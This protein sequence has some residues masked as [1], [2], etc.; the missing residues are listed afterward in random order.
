M[1]DWLWWRRAR[2]ALLVLA[3]VSCGAVRTHRAGGDFFPLAPRST[4]EYVISSRGGRESF[5]FVATVRQGEFLAEDGSACSIVDERYAD[6]SAGQPFPVIYCASGGFLHRVMSLEYQGEAL[7]DN[8][9]RSGETK[10][11]PTDLVHARAWEGRTNAYRLPDGSGFDVEQYHQ[12]AAAPE[13]V[14]VPAGEFSRCVRVET[15][16]VHSAIGAGG[17]PTGPRFVYYYSDW[18]A[19]GVGLVKTEQRSA[20]AEVLA[21]I[22]LVTYEIGGEVAAQ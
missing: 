18:Y 17:E 7:K 5:R 19:P 8:G 22:E 4:W 10:F 14:A 6:A 12:V 20:Q 16:A 15:T 9:L 13:R 3:V 2:G 11:L 1:R 21:T